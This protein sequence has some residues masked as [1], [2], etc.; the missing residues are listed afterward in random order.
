[1]PILGIL[2]SSQT[3][4]LSGPSYESIATQV[5][6][7]SATITFSSIPSTYKHLQIRAQAPVG[8][9]ITGK[10]QFNSDTGSNYSRHTLLGN[11][12]GSVQATSSGASQTYIS[13]GADNG[14]GRSSYAYTMVID[15][16]DYSNTN[17]Y[18][19]MRM[20]A[21][22]DTSATD[23]GE[24]CLESGLWMST[25]AINTITFGTTSGSYST[26]AKFALYGIKG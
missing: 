6:T 20:L 2:A 23:G 9:Y 24:V 12:G 4:N 13:L 21:G 22:F 3:G 10:L 18:K 17:K 11:G 26:A 19:T 7:G 14:Y 5:G 25:S 1:M 16:L 8:N 15:I